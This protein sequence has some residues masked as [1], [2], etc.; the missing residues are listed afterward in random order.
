MPSIITIEKNLMLYAELGNRTAF[1]NTLKSITAAQLPTIDPFATGKILYNLWN[2]A[3]YNIPGMPTPEVT[4]TMVRDFMSKVGAYVRV[5][6]IGE[7]MEKFVQLRNWGALDALTDYLSPAQK[8]QFAHD[9]MDFRLTGT[10]GKILYDAGQVTYS[11]YPEYEA[12]VRDFMTK[13]GKYVSNDGISQALHFAVDSNVHLTNA[14]LDYT[15][16]SRIDAATRL[17]LKNQGYSLKTDGADTVTGTSGYD[18]ISGMGGNDT[19]RGGGGHDVLF[20]NAGNDMLYGDAGNDWLVGGIGADRLT[21]GTGMD[22]FFFDNLTGV[23]TIT[24]FNKSQDYIDLSGLLDNTFDPVTDAIA[25]FVRTT[26]VTSNGVTQTHLSVDVD[27]AGGS[28]GFV[29]VAV[30]NGSVDAKALYDSGHLLV[31]I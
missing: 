28:A 2:S 10:L 9:R 20:G 18:N 15:A 29:N 7:N 16:L 25:N 8:E 24:D 26:S 3:G 1:L 17:E 14:I 23:D 30:I 11:E 12:A 22:F 13:F 27:G 5:D 6:D 19:I 21:G 4:A 31:E